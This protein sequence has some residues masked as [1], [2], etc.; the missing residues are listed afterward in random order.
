LVRDSN[1]VIP[2]TL[3]LLLHVLLFGSLL[4][5]FDFRDRP[6]VAMPLAIKATLVTEEA[7]VVP[8]IVEEKPP[9]PE[10]DTSEQDRIEAE[11]LK[12]K[13]DARVEKER[14]IRLAEEEA[15]RKRRAEEEAEKRRKANEVEKERKRV[16]AERKRQ[17]EIERQRLENERLRQELEAARRAEIEAESDRITA[18][19]ATAEAAYIFAIQQKIVRNWVRP[20]T[21][22]E[23]LECIVN[24]RQL[25]GGEVISVAIG[26]CNG[27]S[28]V[29]RSIEAAVHKASPLPV[30]SDPGVFDRNLRLE[31]RPTEQ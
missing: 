29:R 22:I 4:F 16:E 1:N 24:V 5:A 13:E 26:T 11:E 2:V 15:E 30:P 9:P 31:F 19:A 3:A 14:L 28:T 7:V 23:G 21:A 6:Q 18:M 25:P 8:P 10:P 20:P 12:R 27:D 17:A